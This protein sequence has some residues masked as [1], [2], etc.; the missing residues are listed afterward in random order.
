MESLCFAIHVFTKIE[1]K[2]KRIANRK[3]RIASTKRSE[4]SYDHASQTVSALQ[5]F[6]IGGPSRYLRWPHTT[7]RNFFEEL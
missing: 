6:D 3:K 1:N 4:W 5:S 2:N 7:F